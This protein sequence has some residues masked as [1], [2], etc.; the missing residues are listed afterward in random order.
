MLDSLLVS[1]MLLG[2]VSS[3]GE[4]PFWAGA[5]SYGI[6]PQYNGV[7]SVLSAS[8]QSDQEEDFRWSSG[9]SFAGSFEPG[10][11]VPGAPVA[12]AVFCVDQM[13]GSLGWNAL[14]L[15]VGIRHREQEFKPRNGMG[16]LSVTGG[17]VAW[18]GNARALPG[19]SIILDP[20]S[21]P[22][23]KGHFLV[24]GRYGD[25]LT[26]DKRYVSGAYVHNMLVGL[27]LQFGRFDFSLSL[28]HYAVWGGESPDFGRMPFT[29]DNYFRIATGRSAAAGSS[30]TESDKINVLG[31][32]RGSECFRFR[33]RDEGW[34]LTFQHDVPYDDGSGMGFGN[35]PDGINTLH[36]SLDRDN[37]IT[38]VLYEFGYTMWQSG[39]RHE[40]KDKNGEHKILGG[41]DNYFNNQD[42]KSGWTYYGRTIG[43]PLM[44]PDGT[45]SASWR[46]GLLTLGVENN[47]LIYHHAA[48]AGVLGGLPYRLMLTWS[49]NYGTYK[50]PYEGESQIYQDWGTVRETPVRQ[51]SAALTGSVPAIFNNSRLNLNWGIYCDSGK[52][53]RR[54]FGALLGI[55]IKIY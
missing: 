50:A 20:V 23:T 29:L 1:L 45:R 11:A 31:D 44:F 26:L 32:H 40:G 16:T 43:L 30:S 49:S 42:Y 53:L 25:Y 39:T 38:D 4:L 7:A 5:N 19:Y 51:F 10:M 8:A 14:S 47:R 37:G 52:V 34:S 6:M 3:S 9:L 41:L 21:V 15:D 12:P 17:N 18:S 48:V 27:M 28:D 13:Y 33:W 46:R 36:L 54:S 2:A 55:G 22:F 24:Y 35:F